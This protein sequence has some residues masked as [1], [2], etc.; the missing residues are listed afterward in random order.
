[1]NY[2]YRIAGPQDRDN[3][4]DFINYV[5]SFSHRPHDFKALYPREYRDGFEGNAV[6]FLALNEAGQIRAVVAV[7]P[8]E[9]QIAA[10]RLSCGFIG[11]VSVHPYARGEGHMKKLMA[12]ANQWMMERHMDLAVLDGHRQRYQYYGYSK[13]GAAFR[14]A[15]I[16]DNIRHGLKDVSTAPYRI[17]PVG[18]PDDDVLEKIHGLHSQTPV[19]V[20]RNLSQMYYTLTGINHRLYA[21]WKEDC[22]AG[23]FSASGED[24][25]S[26]LLLFDASDYAPVI[27]LWSN[28]CQK[29]RFDIFVPAWDR[30]IAEILDTFA[31]A[32]YIQQ[33]GNMRVFCWEHALPAMLALKQMASG[34]LSD[35]CLRLL[36]DGQEMSL[37]VE[38]G[39]ISFSMGHAADSEADSSGTDCCHQDDSHSCAILS[40]MDLQEKIFSTGSFLH[41]RPVG[42]E[43]KDWF[44]IPFSLPMPDHF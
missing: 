5:F 14:Y 4:I 41:P 33:G 23:Y 29:E 18:S 31:E 22:F 16:K 39:I 19:H 28:I 1:M 42:G 26:E 36:I 8:F 34:P 2:T 20:I 44:P 38:K 12:M 13:G 27:K 15:V 10:H 17:E 25:L 35:G 3:Y 32:A 43:P 30:G 24:S 11:S 9:M 21:V 40:S 6:H 7:L 37:W